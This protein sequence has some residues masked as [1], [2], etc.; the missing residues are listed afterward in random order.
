MSGALFVHTFL[1][2][3]KP[4]SRN[5]LRHRV[6]TQKVRG[7]NKE[8]S[9]STK[10]RIRITMKFIEMVDIKVKICAGSLGVLRRRN[11]PV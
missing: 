6:I 5:L 3:Q 11:D 2:P 9:H 8:I 10:K 1:A 7:P 4:E